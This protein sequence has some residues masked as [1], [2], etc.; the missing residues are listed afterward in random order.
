MMKLRRGCDCQRQGWDLT[1]VLPSDPVSA[2]SRAH[3][4]SRA[5]LLSMR[6]KIPELET[7][8][9]REQTAPTFSVTLENGTLLQE[10][11]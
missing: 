6:Q 11:Q 5:V 3:Q 1:Q 9:G 10:G 4:Q 8:H 2:C 7:Y